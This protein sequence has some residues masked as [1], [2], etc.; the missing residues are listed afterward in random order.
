MQISAQR[1][2]CLPVPPPQSSYYSLRVLKQ[3]KSL[4]P[5]QYITARGREYKDLVY[6]KMV[7]DDMWP[8]EPLTGRVKVDVVI[9]LKENRK[10]DLDN[11]A[12]CLFDTLTKLRVWIDDSQIDDLR[13]RRGEKR[14]PDG[15]CFVT[16]EE[17]R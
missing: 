10:Y 2:Y 5:I 7:E 12:K 1:F 11:R 16:V 4:V 8:V 14:T 6:E 3:S 15:M 9:H 17:I 13:I